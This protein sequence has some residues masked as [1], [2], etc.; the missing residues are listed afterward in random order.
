MKK[1]AIVIRT[2]NEEKFLFE[3]LSTIFRQETEFSYE[4]II[5][6]S[7][8][9][10][11]TL[12]I[13]NKFDTKIVSIKKEDF[14][15]GYSLNKGIEKSN[16][17]FCLFLSAHCIPASLNWLT[18]MI[19][20]FSDSN[21]ALVYG[22]QRGNDLT[23]YSEQQIFKRWFP[24]TSFARQKSPFCNNANS[25]IRKSLWE[26][27]KYDETLTGLEDLAWAK[28]IL[29]LEEK[30]YYLYYNSNASVYHIHEENYSQVFNRYKREAITLHGV[31][32]E[33]KFNFVDFVKLSI[34]NIFTDYLHSYK[35]NLFLK[36]VKD[37]TL[38][39]LA[40]FWGTYRGHKLTK[41]ISAQLR[42]RFYY[43]PKYVKNEESIENERIELNPNTETV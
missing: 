11:N 17:E 5:V 21:V 35:D 31:L 26:K 32:K 10:D 39:R 27:I 29:S 3:V 36:S 8:S 37:I 20:P 40:Q 34:L 18:Q 30:R 22:K 12:K 14:S 9:T 16:A 23:R 25:V 43:P 2:Y 38:F 19:T 6:D 33:V 4:V 28:K 1:I 41:N 42:E 24:N 7:G 13:A 15:F